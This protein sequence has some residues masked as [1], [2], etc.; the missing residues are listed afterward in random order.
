ME[1]DDEGDI[2]TDLEKDC[3]VRELKA[4]RTYLLVRY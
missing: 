4:E 3:E 1:L 2:S